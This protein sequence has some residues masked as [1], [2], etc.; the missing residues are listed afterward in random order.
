MLKLNEINR[1]LEYANGIKED[2]IC[3]YECIVEI[4]GKSDNI[5]YSL[6]ILLFTNDYKLYNQYS[7]G[8]REN[9][10]EYVYALKYLKQRI[11]NE[12]F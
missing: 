2:L 4:R 9:Y 6:N 12:C 11:I 7:T 5:G 3:E 1:L 10:V 8:V